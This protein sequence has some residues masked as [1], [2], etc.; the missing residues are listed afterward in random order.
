LTE[1]KFETGHI[2]KFDTTTIL[3]KALSYMDGLIKEVIDIRLHQ[4]NI[5]RGGAFHSHSVLI[6]GD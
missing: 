5:N 1:H 4:R 3:D 2:I 6:L